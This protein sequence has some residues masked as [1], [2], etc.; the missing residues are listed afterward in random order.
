MSYLF[1][2]RVLTIVYTVSIFILLLLLIISV[3][4]ILSD[5]RLLQSKDDTITLSPVEGAKK[6]ILLKYTGLRPG[7]K[8][9]EELLSDDA[10]N[11]PTPHHK[12]MVSMDPYKEYN[13]IK[14]L[15]EQLE[16][17]ALSHDNNQIVRI[18]KNM[19]PEFISNNS[20]FE[21]LD[22]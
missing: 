16:A 19:V 5:I 20:I 1:D 12:I 22:R 11:L 7:E 2:S 14:D 6:D 9:Y 8:L 15:I 21:K 18:I 13:E 10:K 3:V 17:A 4:S